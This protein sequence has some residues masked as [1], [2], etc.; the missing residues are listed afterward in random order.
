MRSIPLFHSGCRPGSVRRRTQWLALVLSPALA[1]T[2]LGCRDGAEPPTAPPASTV[3]AAE[4]AATATLSFR[5]ISAGGLHTCA[6]TTNDLAYCWGE[7]HWTPAPVPGGLRFLLVSAGETNRGS[8]GFTCGLATNR[9]AYCWGTDLVPV[10]VPG[11]RRFRQISTGYGYSCAVTTTDVAFCW[12]VNNYLGQLGTGG[13][14]VQEPTRVAGGLRWRSVF[15]SATHTCGVTLDDVGYCWG[16][17]VLGQLGSGIANFS[18]PKPVKIA[19]GL[20]FDQVKPGSGVDFGLNSTEVDIAT[21]CGITR[22]DRAYCWGAYGAIGSEVER[23]STPLQVA[24][25]RRYD[26]VHPGAVHT[27]ALTVT[28]V[29]F[30]WGDNQAGQLGIGTFA[31]SPTPVRVAGGL[32]FVSL[33]VAPTGAHSCGITETNQAY[34]WGSNNTGQL[35][36]GSHSNRPK[37]VPVAGAM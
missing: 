8:E 28:S 17:N 37:P 13:G 11:G 4:A 36:D 12:G 5:Q 19:G 31:S 23:T 15:T 1:L 9:Q 30:C 34:C 2:A 3:S 25:G 20:R 35:G 32:R 22:N 14:A 7:G 27:C 24:G 29:A 16:Y 33:T 18:N 10:A 6:V 26:F 21:T